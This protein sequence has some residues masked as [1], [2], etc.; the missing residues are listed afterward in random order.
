MTQMSHFHLVEYVRTILKI[1]PADI[2]CHSQEFQSVVRIPNHQ[3]DKIFVRN[4]HRAHSYTTQNENL[5]KMGEDDP[6]KNQKQKN[7]FIYYL[8]KFK[9]QFKTN[10]LKLPFYK[11]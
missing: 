8:I 9:K 11:H 2:L 10:E 7:C 6:I 5:M 3:N 4:I 1:G